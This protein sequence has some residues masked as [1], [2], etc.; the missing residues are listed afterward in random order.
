[1]LQSRNFLSK[2]NQIQCLGKVTPSTFNASNKQSK[3]I[4]LTVISAEN[5]AHNKEVGE[6]HVLIR[7]YD[8][9]IVQ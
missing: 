6:M 5:I 2:C 8:Q 4:A 7:K 9:S 1:M 3:Q